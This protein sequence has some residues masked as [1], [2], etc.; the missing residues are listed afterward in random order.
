MNA[1]L[2]IFKR[3][4]DIEFITNNK[5]SIRVPI[6]KSDSVL[7]ALLSKGIDIPY[8]CKSG[9]CQTCKMHCLNP[10]DLPIHSNKNL[11]TTEQAL[12]YFLPC[13]CKPTK[14]L[15][16]SPISLDTL[17]H[18]TKVIERTFVSNKIIRLRLEALFNFKGGQ[19][20]NLFKTDQLSRAYS[21][22]STPEDGF[23]EFH[24]KCITGGAFSEWA[25]TDLNVGDTI[26]V[27][28]PL[29]TCFYIS[30]NPEQ[31][32]LLSGIGTGLAPLLGIIKTAL[33]NKHQ[34]PID[35]ILGAKNTDDFYLK[36]TLYAL[37]QKH[38]YLTVHWVAQS[39]NSTSDHF[40]KDDLYHYVASLYPSLKDHQVFLCGAPSFVTK[41]QKQCFLSDAAISNIYCDIFEATK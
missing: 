21:I 11:Q 14:T 3:K 7:D 1:L 29:G 27:S 10:D 17:T 37:S 41:M 23:L 40:L 34:A 32:L 2:S 31:P 39:V 12:G 9:L 16:I 6:S 4:P 8:S 38:P 28:A 25:S 5:A 15:K 22:A 18:S 26:K 20:C 24:I 33:L 36:E 13:I 19:F 35:L 30:A